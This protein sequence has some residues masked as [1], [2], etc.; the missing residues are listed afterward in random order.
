MPS[1]VTVTVHQGSRRRVLVSTLAQTFPNE[2]CSMD[3]FGATGHG[4][5]RMTY[6]PL[7]A[8]SPVLVLPTG[9]TPA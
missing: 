2:P 6:K 8:G 1:N 5:L 9:S 4:I 3:P 7:R